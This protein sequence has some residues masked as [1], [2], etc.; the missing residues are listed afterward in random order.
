MQIIDLTPENTAL[1]V[2]VANLLVDAFRSHSAAWPDVDAGLETV[3]EL[4]EE[5]RISRV[6]I[7]DDGTVLGWIGANEQ[8]DGHVWELDPLVVRVDQQ[9]RGI[10]RALVADLEQ[11]VKVR[12]GI[13]MILGTDDEDNRTSLGGKNLYPDVLQNGMQIKNVGGHPFEFYQKVG[14]VIIGLIP[15]ANGPGKPDIL[16]AKRIK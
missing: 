12:G 9:G 7:D 15:D 14:F 1:I 16:M 2:E 10:G 13:T 11:Q 8:Y 5:G 4:F 6:A 3:Q